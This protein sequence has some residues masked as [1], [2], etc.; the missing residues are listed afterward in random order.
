RALRTF[1]ASPHRNQ[2]NAGPARYIR[3]ALRRVLRIVLG[4]ERDLTLA[5]PLERTADTGGDDCVLTEGDAAQGAVEPELAQHRQ[6]IRGALAGALIGGG[7]RAPGA[8]LHEAQ[9]DLP[10][11]QGVDAVLSEGRQS[12]EDQV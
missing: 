5:A 6:R 10:D 8:G 3:D 12:S 7:D 1:Y 11:A 2:H 4:F 9:R